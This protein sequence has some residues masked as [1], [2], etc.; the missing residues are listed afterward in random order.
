MKKKKIH[1]HSFPD[2]NA[3]A[4]GMENSNFKIW[5]FPNEQAMNFHVLSFLS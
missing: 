2:K 4:N 5:V 1:Y 3:V